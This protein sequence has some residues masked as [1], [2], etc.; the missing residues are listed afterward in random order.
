LHGQQCKFMAL[1]SMDPRQSLC[2]QT[3]Q[4]PLSTA[5]PQSVG[6]QRFYSVKSF[7]KMLCLGHGHDL[8]PTRG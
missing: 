8:S 1:T 4:H 2:A 7:F 3:H 5:L 6:L